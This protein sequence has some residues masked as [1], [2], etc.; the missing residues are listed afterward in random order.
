MIRQFIRQ[1]AHVFVH[2]V[3]CLLDFRRLLIDLI[4]LEW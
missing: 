2:L 4:L 1:L 3:I